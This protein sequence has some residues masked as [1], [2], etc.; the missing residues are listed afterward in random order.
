MLLF[1]LRY[2]R[3]FAR[4]IKPIR[5]DIKIVFINSYKNRMKKILFILIS[6]LCIYACT[7]TDYVINGTVD[8]EAL[9]GTTIFL[10]QRIDRE[11]ITIDST[12][13]SDKSFAF[14]GVCDTAKIAYVMYEFPEGN[15]VRQAF[16]LENGKISV[17]VDTTGFMTFAGTKQNELLQSYQ[18]EKNAK[19]KRRE[20]R[21]RRH[22]NYR[23][24]TKIVG[25]RNEES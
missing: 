2:I 18:K 8:N 5:I 3:I 4:K 9:N 10:K 16:V 12:V 17:A 25:R 15:S 11:W 7:P 14:Q 6:A 23:R 19:G 20:Q 1:C 24:A 13:I 22:Y 21:T